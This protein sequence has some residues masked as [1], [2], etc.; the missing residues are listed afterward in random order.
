MNTFR[1]KTKALVAAVAMTASV[2]ASATAL[3]GVSI[4]GN[5]IVWLENAGGLLLPK[6]SPTASDIS[7]ALGGNA[8]APGGNVELSKF[9]GPVTTLSGV[10][11]STNVTLSSLT[12]DDWTGNGNALAA[13]YIQDAAVKTF[14]AP[15]SSA[16][17]STA[18]TNFLNVDID[19]S[20]SSVRYMWQMV[21]DPNISYVD[22][23]GC[24]LTVGLAGL[25]DATGFLNTLSAG[26]GAPVLTGTNQV[27]EV[28]KVTRDGSG[29]F[30]LY[31][32]TATPSGVHAADRVSYTGNFEVTLLPEPASLALF[33]IG[34]FGLLATRRRR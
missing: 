23:T 17:L 32:F 16:N 12:W 31:G 21:S 22:V 7:T 26:T 4:S 28:V 10:A 30:Y 24:I 18:L 2:G 9:G 19:P 33:G 20:P 8:A 3:T 5:Y 25:F 13:R 34:L 14:G 29:P 15:L 1:Y 11:G 6:S 27:S